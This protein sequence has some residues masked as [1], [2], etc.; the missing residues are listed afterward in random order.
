M[1]N[2]RQIED[3]VIYTDGGARQNESAAAACV[4]EEVVTRKRYYLG[5]FLGSGTNNEGE[6]SAS[7]LGFAYIRAKLAVGRASLSVRWVSDSEYALKSG[8]AYIIQWQKNGWRTAGKA[9]VKNQGL[10]KV[11]LH[12]TKG[13]KIIAEHVRGHTGHP[14]NELCDRASNWLREAVSE[15]MPV[16]TSID[17]GSRAV[18]NQVF[19]GKDWIV[20]D[21]RSFMQMMR[22][23]ELDRHSLEYLESLFGE[24]RGSTN[25]ER[26][27]AIKDV[28]VPKA[29]DLFASN[30]EVV[31]PTDIFSFVKGEL[32]VILSDLSDGEPEGKLVRIRQRLSKVIERMT[33]EE[34]AHLF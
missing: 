2:A 3:Y 33:S 30:R 26:I 32:Q 25:R 19:E 18:S 22:G 12:L 4:V 14:E 16:E 34:N 9:P 8:T 7:L 27:T 11:F 10:W 21:G 17:D 24:K 23:S 1:S 29:Q 5:M 28:K 20:V 15:L 13:L 6:I 31:E